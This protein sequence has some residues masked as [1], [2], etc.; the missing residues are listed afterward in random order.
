VQRQT[1]ALA[2]GLALA[3][4]G[5]DRDEKLCTLIGAYSGVR[6]L[7][8]DYLP[9]APAGWRVEVCLRDECKELAGAEMGRPGHPDIDGRLVFPG[10]TPVRTSLSVTVKSADDR[11]IART[12]LVVLPSRFRPNGPDCEPDVAQAGIELDAQGRAHPALP[13]VVSPTST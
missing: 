7:A 2:A 3:A 8:A 6:V 12:D 1:V 4:L 9:H 5:C 13:S 10:L 11:Q